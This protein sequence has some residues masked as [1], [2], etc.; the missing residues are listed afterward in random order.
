MVV[1]H[2]FYVEVV[3]TQTLPRALALAGSRHSFFLFWELTCAL[4][5]MT[6]FD[7]KASWRDIPASIHAIVQ[8]RETG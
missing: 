8:V 2:V 5:P 1:L 7:Y 3:R 6:Q 4:I